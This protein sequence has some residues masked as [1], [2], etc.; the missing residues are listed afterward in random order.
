VG[1]TGAH[2][3]KAAPVLYLPPLRNVA[4]TCSALPGPVGSRGFGPANLRGTRVAAGPCPVGASAATL[5]HAV[6]NVARVTPRLSRRPSLSSAPANGPS[7]WRW[8]CSAAWGAA[9]SRAPCAF[10]GAN[11]RTSRVMNN[12]FSPVVFN[13]V[14][15][16][17][18]KS[19]FVARVTES[20]MKKSSLQTRYYSRT[21]PLFQQPARA[22]L[23]GFSAAAAG[24]PGPSLPRS[25]KPPSPPTAAVIS[26]S[27]WMAPTSNAAAKRLRPPSGSATP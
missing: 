27:A 24:S 2:P 12:V 22:P 20:K 19:G 1:P 15:F 4:L 7:P 23:T 9:P 10:W 6:R 11:T 5:A 14:Q 18:A 16:R 17:S 25:S 3:Q 8:A 13:F 26:P 21:T